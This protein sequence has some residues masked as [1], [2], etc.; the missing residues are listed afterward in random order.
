MKNQLALKMTLLLASLFAPVVTTV[1]ARAQSD[2][3]IP[4]GTRFMVE[5]HDKI[6]AG[7][8]KRGKK[9]EARTLEAL[10]AL[11]GRIIPAG[12]KIKGRVSHAE[13]NRLMLYFREIETRHETIPI[14]ATVIQVRDERDIRVEPGREGEMETAAHRGRDAAIGAGIG[15]GMGAAAGAAKGGDEAA[16]IGAGVGAG[17]GALIG[18]SNSGGDLVLHDGSRLELQ[19]ER[20]LLIP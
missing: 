7:R 6:D 14:V 4:A 5:L 10:Q 12:A 11:D 17:L 2:S 15:A 16:A 19:L 3:E 20:A 18:A 9:F 1:S 13:G 8:A